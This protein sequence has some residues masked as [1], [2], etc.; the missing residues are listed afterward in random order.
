MRVLRVLGF[1]IIGVSLWRFDCSAEERILVVCDE[2]EQMEVLG[3]FLGEEGKYEVQIV[4]QEDFPND[5]SGYRGVFNFVHR[6]LTEKVEDALMAYAL[7]GGRL[8]TLHHGISS[9]KMLNKKWLPFCGVALLQGDREKGGWSVL[10][11][12]TAEL[13][14]LRPDHYITSHK[15]SYEESTDYIPSD[16]P[17]TEQTC[18]VL[19]LPR[20]EVFLN[21]HFTD[22][23][24]KEVLFG[25]KG[26]DPET[27]KVY[28]QDRGGWFH[29]KGKGWLFYFQ[30]GHGTADFQNRS[31]CQILLNCLTWDAKSDKS[32]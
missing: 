16:F 21:E 26:A 25:V 27:G 14:N 7:S 10:G 8:I 13:V 12:V 31:Y 30:I 18:S 19:R 5:L 23:R 32:R 15:V 22:G 29:R 9:S 11:N 17:S 6:P 28:M 1:V 3:K 4:A 24:E 2:R 20:S